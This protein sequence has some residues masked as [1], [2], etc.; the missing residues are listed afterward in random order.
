MPTIMTTADIIFADIRTKYVINPYTGSQA[1]NLHYIRNTNTLISLQD[2]HITIHTN[3]ILNSGHT[4][5]TI[6]YADPNCNQ[7]I[8]Q[9]IRWSLRKDILKRY[10]IPP[11]LEVS[12]CIFMIIALAGLVSSMIWVSYFRAP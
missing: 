7:K 4:T 9:R 2:T 3:N 5:Y 6:N 8:D 1:E 12:M 10:V 11:S